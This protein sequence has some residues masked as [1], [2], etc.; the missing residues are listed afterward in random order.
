M[1]D[2]TKED[3]K[4]LSYLAFH[5]QTIGNHI[6]T[7]QNASRASKRLE[8]KNLI[9]RTSDKYNPHPRPA[10]MLTLTVEGLAHA[11][12]I[13]FM[14]DRALRILD[15]AALGELDVIVKHWNELLPDVF[16]KWHFFRR[17][18]VERIAAERL[19]YAALSLVN[20]FESMSRAGHLWTPKRNTTNEEHMGDVFTK[21]F[22]DLIYDPTFSRVEPLAKWVLSQRKKKFDIRDSPFLLWVDVLKNHPDTRKKIDDNIRIARSDIDRLQLLSALLGHD[23]VDTD[24]L[25]KSL[26]NVFRMFYSN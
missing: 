18:N 26:V 23:A 11:L 13:F 3:R 7:L 10:T 6:K 8:S 16:E 5:G 20:S 14:K 24:K 2:L 12:I 1:I 4:L 22:Y 25:E 19:V 15:R 9:A 17:Y 21:F